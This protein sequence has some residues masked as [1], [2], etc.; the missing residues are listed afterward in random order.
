MKSYL[1]KVEYLNSFVAKLQRLIST[2]ANLK[3]EKLYYKNSVI[4][5]NFKNY[6]D[7][8]YKN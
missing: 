7:Q 1:E 8:N 3:N 5:Y 4:N 6:Y 2:V